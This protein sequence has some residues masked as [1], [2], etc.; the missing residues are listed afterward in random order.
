M[1]LLQSMRGSGIFKH[2]RQ[3]ISYK[4]F[5]GSGNREHGQKELQ[6]MW[7]SDICEHG[8]QRSLCKQSLRGGAVSA[9][10]AD[11]GLLA[12]SAGTVTSA[13]MA[14]RKL[15]A[16]SVGAV[17]FASMAGK[18]PYN[19]KSAEAVASARMADRRLFAKSAGQWHERAWQKKSF[20][21]EVRGGGGASE[22]VCAKNAKVLVVFTSI[23]GRSVS[24]RNV[25][26]VASASMADKPTNLWTMIS[27]S[28]SIMSVSAKSAEAMLSAGMAV[29]R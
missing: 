17:A 8:G 24:A 18:G 21:Q 14:G 1:E 16:S 9:K 2:G 11:K 25:T 10:M 29:Q 7:G 5:G 20:L 19:A 27:A 28:I 12:R 15:L 4:E 22:R 6:G 13:N 26:A 3:R 23:A